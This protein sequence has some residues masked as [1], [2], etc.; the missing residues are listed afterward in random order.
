MFAS[1]LL[2][3]VSFVGATYAAPLTPLRR[4]VSQIAA[5]EL[6]GFAPTTQFARAAYC[7]IDEL[8]DWSCGEACDALADFTPTLVDIVGYWPSEDAVVVV[9]E[10]TDPLQ[11]ESVLT[12]IDALK[13]TLDPT[14]FPGVGGDVLVHNG[15]SDQHA[16]TASTILAEV[17]SLMAAHGTSNLTLA[18]HSLGGA[19]AEL[20]SLFF[21]LNI[22]SARIK[23]RTYG[24]PRV[25]NL[26]F[27]EL[28][29]SMV[30]DFLRINNEDDLIPIVP[31]RG[32]GF[33]HPQG[34]THILGPGN[35]VACP[36]ND[37][38]VDDQCQIKSVPNIFVGNILNHLGPY[39]G[40]YIGTIFCT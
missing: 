21:A 27:A 3:T 28:I 4:A 18:G 24:T 34:E 14:L 15:F 13:D 10:G 37:D 11:F 40:I 19:L 17:N 2:M 38:A 39:E 31:G 22:P 29:D 12:D 32:L 20:D 35:A 26:A 1:T 16:L 8:Q 25:G 33:S 7:P 6:S 30:P 23:A 5:T 9:H 36:G